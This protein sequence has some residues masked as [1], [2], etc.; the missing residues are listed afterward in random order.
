MVLFYLLVGFF[1]LKIDVV[2]A[3]I[4]RPKAMLPIGALGQIS[5]TPQANAAAVNRIIIL[6]LI[7][8]FIIL[9]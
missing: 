1:N 7:C 9:F 2:N 6:V 4:A 3:M 8:N 5:R